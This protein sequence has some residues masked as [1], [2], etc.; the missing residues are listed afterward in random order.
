MYGS[1]AKKQMKIGKIIILSMIC[2]FAHSTV[3]A[4]SKKEQ[5][6]DLK[7][8][9]RIINLIL[10]S[11]TVNMEQCG[12]VIP[13]PNIMLT[14]VPQGL[15]HDPSK[16]VMIPQGLQTFSVVYHKDYWGAV[17]N[18]GQAIY[19]GSARSDLIFVNGLIGKGKIY[20]FDYKTVKDSVAVFLVEVTDS[21]LLSNAET[22]IANFREF[23]S[24]TPVNPK[25]L[26][27]TYETKN[28]KNWITFS[29]N[30]ISLNT[31][32]LSSKVNCEG[33]FQFSENI[34]IVQLEPITVGKN[35]LRYFGTEIWYYKLN[36]TVLEIIDIKKEY[37]MLTSIKKG[38]YHRR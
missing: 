33:S 9:E 15:L 34:I 6:A 13:N 1:I 38:E 17:N 23:M 26:E 37:G 10:A 12:Y 8:T 16:I 7:S 4:Q 20:T 28:G 31:S 3:I 29:G 21:K 14:S 32:I 24:W 5:E 35:Q 27:G 30:K 19:T 2:L 22:D 11:E 25:M 36:G 18:R